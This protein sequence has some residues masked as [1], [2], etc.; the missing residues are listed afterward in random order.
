MN[1]VNLRMSEQMVGMVTHWSH[2]NSTKVALMDVIDF[3]LKIDPE[4]DL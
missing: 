1:E 4:N 2:Y 3:F